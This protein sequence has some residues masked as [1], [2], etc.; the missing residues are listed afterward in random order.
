MGAFPV[1]NAIL[2]LRQAV[3]GLCIFLGASSAPGFESAEH[4]RMGDLALRVAKSYIADRNIAIADAAHQALEQFQGRKMSYGQIVQ[5]VDFYLFP[6][7]IFAYAWR[8]DKPTGRTGVAETGAPL[9]GDLIAKCDTEGA[10]YIQASHSNHAHF[11]QDLMMSFRLSHL[12]AYALAKE[13]GNYYGGL[14]A[15]AIADHY[16]QDFFA[17]G[18]I[19]TPRDRLT[20]VPATAMH[21]LANRQGANFRPNLTEGIRNILQYLC[22]SITKNAS[23]IE[24]LRCSSGDAPDIKTLIGPNNTKEQFAAAIDSLMR[25]EDAVIFR[26]DGY[27]WSTDFEQLKQRILLLAV[28]TQSILDILTVST[29]SFKTFYFAYELRTGRTFADVDFGSYVF[30]KEPPNFRVADSPTSEPVAAPAPGGRLARLGDNVYQL[31]TR[32]RTVG[33]SLHRESLSSGSRAGRNVGAVEVSVG[34]SIVDLNSWSK[35]LGSYDISQ[36][37][38]YQWYR[39]GNLRGSG[40]TARFPLSIPETEVSIGPYFRYLSYQTDQGEKRKLTTGLRIDSGFSG[41][42]TFYMGLGKDYGVETNRSLHRGW[43][44]TMGIQAAFPSSRIPF[45]GEKVPVDTWN[46]FN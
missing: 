39:E 15:N 22:G 9:H 35:Y 4:K 7:K 36:K 29:N 30:D 6:E 33:L 14:V 44:W 45:I 28:E 12:L 13:E 5:C 26:G 1:V 40:P 41:Y 46:S 31:T 38:G 10:A 17:L 21:D 19:V 2:H 16:L 32:A 18:H 25:N 23:Q 34:G 8:H 11:Q 27:L 20:D 37:I 43:L 24:T 42:F 3:F